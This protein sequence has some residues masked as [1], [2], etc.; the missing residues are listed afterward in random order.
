[1][2]TTTKLEFNEEYG[3]LDIRVEDN[4]PPFKVYEYARVNLR[5][6]KQHVEAMKS[7]RRLLKDLSEQI[8]SYV[9]TLTKGDK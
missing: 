9:S 7:A 8:E 2:G 1:M 6:I 5:E 3:Q 4:H